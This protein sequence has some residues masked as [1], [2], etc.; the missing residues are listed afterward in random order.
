MLFTVDTQ[1]TGAL[2]L[3]APNPEYVCDQVLIGGI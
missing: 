3:D 2:A 1:G